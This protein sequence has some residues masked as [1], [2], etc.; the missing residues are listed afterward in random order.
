MKKFTL[1]SLVLVLTLGMFAQMNNRA[2]TTQKFQKKEKADWVQRYDNKADADQA[3]KAYGDIYFEDDFST[4]SV[5]N[6]PTGWTTVDV[7]DAGNDFVWEWTTTGTTGQYGSA[8]FESTSAANGWLMLDSDGYGQGSYDALVSSPTYDLTGKPYVA[9]KFEEYYRRWGNEAT[10]PYGGNPTYLGVVINGVDTTEI[11]LHSDFEVSDGTANPENVMVN[12]SLVAGNEANVQFYF[13]I[14]GLWDYWWHIDDFKLIE[15]AGNDLEIKET[16][17]LSVYQFGTQGFNWFGYYSQLP[18]SQATPF[19][20]QTDV[21]NNGVIDQTNAML[22]VDVLFDGTSTA[23]LTDT[24]A[25]HP[26]D[27]TFSYV[28]EWYTP[29]AAGN[30]GATFTMSQ[31]QVEEVPE[32][33][34][35]GPIEWEVTTNNIMARDVAW[36][37][38]LGANLYTDG[39]D[40]DFLGVSYFTANA[41]EVNSLSVFI[42]YRCDVGTIIIGQVY[43][44]DTDWVLKIESEEHI[45]TEADLGHWINLPL[46]TIDPTDDDL[47]AESEYLAGVEMYWGGGDLNCWI[48]ADD[49]GP[50]IYSQVTQLRIGQDWFWVSDM[51][52]VRMNLDG[53]IEPPVYTSNTV[54]TIFVDPA[55]LPWTTSL[56]VEAT[57]PGSLALSFDTI[58]VLPAFVT[59]FVDNGNGTASINMTITADDISEYLYTNTAGNDIYRSYRLSYVVDNGTVDNP[60]YSN[61]YVFEGTNNV[62]TTEASELVIYPNPTTSV[63]NVAN[64]EGASIRVYNIVGELVASVENAS[65]LAQLDL[66]AYSNGTYFVKVVNGNETTTQKVN[67]IK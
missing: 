51:P 2:V 5:G 48:G 25:V 27:S 45:I 3:L 22:T 64:V 39:S 31:D 41:T 30:F 50:H 4:G 8:P 34:F 12:V 32:S 14:K 11:E 62:A 47:D 43:S 29:T 17:A 65:N 67:L 20:F 56:T 44:S 13:R 60:M 9:V 59:S 52:M 1:L 66:S 55:A 33:N 10:N 54:D 37:R 19:F 42:D 58:D 46:I 16:Y 24:I 21:F 15:G 6:M 18:L 36:S 49:E 53:A 40:G 28:P 26:V 23:Q 7:D 61:I 63:I 57:D 35:S 38:A